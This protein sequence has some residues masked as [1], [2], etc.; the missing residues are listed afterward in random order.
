M[1]RDTDVRNFAPFDRDRLVTEGTYWDLIILQV[2]LVT[3]VIQVQVMILAKDSLT[4]I[5]PHGQ[6]VCQ[7][8]TQHNNQHLENENNDYSTEEIRLLTQLLA[9]LDEAV[10]TELREL[11]LIPLVWLQM[12]RHL[13]TDTL[14]K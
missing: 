11:H 8:I 3:R 10:F 5:A 12:R 14:V 4:G 6:E 1:V 2:G 13:V 9:G 7:M